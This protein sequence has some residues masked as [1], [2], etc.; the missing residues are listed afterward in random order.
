MKQT[1]HV[2]LEFDVPTHQF[3][4]AHLE[5]IFRRFTKAFDKHPLDDLV[6]EYVLKDG[7]GEQVGTAR[8]LEPRPVK[9]PPAMSDNLAALALPVLQQMYRNAKHTGHCAAGHEKAWRNY[10]AA[11]RYEAEMRRR[12][13]VPANSGAGVFNGLGAV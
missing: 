4:E 8:I 6:G 12:G 1:I 13:R 2:R 10:Q 9:E 7:S 5:G 11:D 3:R